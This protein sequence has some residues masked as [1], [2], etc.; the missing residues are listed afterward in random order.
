[1]E[2][3]GGLKVPGEK[4]KKRVLNKFVNICLTF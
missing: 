1:M 3:G 2:G 4:N